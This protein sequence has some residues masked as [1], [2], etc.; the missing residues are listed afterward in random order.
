VTGLRTLQLKDFGDVSRLVRKLRARHPLDAAAIARLE[1]LQSNTIR[2]DRGRDIIEAG[3]QSDRIYIIRNGW[4]ARFKLLPDGRRQIFNFI[5]PG[6]MFGV[7]LNSLNNSDHSICAIT[8]L[9]VSWCS[10]SALADVEAEFPQIA[11]A[12]Q[13][14]NVREWS[15][16]CE[17]LVS[18]GR[19][20]ATNRI[21]HLMLELHARLRLVDETRGDTFDLPITQE[22]IADSL[23]LT[24]VHVSRSLGALR[25]RGLVRYERNHVVLLD[26][27]RLADEIGF[28][29]DYLDQRAPSDGTRCQ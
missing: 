29:D 21:A 14:E 4:A 20:C 7:L 5:L 25:Q 16:M 18:V 10:R 12:V 26:A 11:A 15:I 17:R 1:A 2:M 8:D 28:S 3:N 22:M 6:D 23:G 27:V 13:W 9:W 19:R 24:H